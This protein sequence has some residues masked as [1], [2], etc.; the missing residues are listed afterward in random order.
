MKSLLLLSLLVSELLASFVAVAQPA[1]LSE[2][3]LTLFT[4]G[5]S[6]GTFPYSWP[7][8]VKSAFPNAKVVNISRSG[9][10]IGFVN[11][12]DSTLNSL[13]VADVNL[14]KAAESSNG[15]AYDFILI[16]LGTNDAKAVFAD[17]QAEVP[18]NLEKLIRR[19]RACPYPVLNKAKIVI[20]SP[21]PYGTKAL[22]TEKYAGGGERVKAMSQTFKQ[23][24]QRNQCLF[25][26][27]FTTPG[28]DIE[29]MTPDGL[30]L[31][32]AGSR[33]LIEPLVTLLTH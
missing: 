30:H 16:E 26:D 14:K 21:P 24:A 32:A 17:R 33:K 22:S 25:V 29:T 19:I 12:G 3:R 23:V 2:K 7:Q 4:L 31:D 15:Q 28:L 13:L 27:G 8:Q 6:N 11:N 1:V 5:D 10:T 9:R 18:L 20:I